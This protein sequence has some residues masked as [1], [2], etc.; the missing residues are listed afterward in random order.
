[1]KK[2]SPYSLENLARQRWLNQQFSAV[3]RDISVH[4]APTG[5]KPASGEEYWEFAIF[6][7][8]LTTPSQYFVVGGTWGEAFDRLE[9][10]AL[11]MCQYEEQ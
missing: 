8:T 7:R 10:N 1:M 6:Y 5:E 11:N 3:F 9:R 2:A 4:E